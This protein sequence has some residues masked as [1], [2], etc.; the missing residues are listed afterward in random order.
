MPKMVFEDLLTTWEKNYTKGLLTLWLL[1]VLDER[2]AYAFEMGKLVADLSLGSVEVDD[3]S[4]YRALKRFAKLGIVESNWGESG[5]GPKRRYYQLSILGKE[6][7]QAFIRKNILI[8]Q[9][10]TVS[11]RI[12]AA[13]DQ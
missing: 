13:I 6:L 10:D 11:A 12:Q 3:N 7:L 2:K 4:I 8:F 9:T 1:L 5:K